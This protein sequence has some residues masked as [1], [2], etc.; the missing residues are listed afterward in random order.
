VATLAESLTTLEQ[1]KATLEKTVKG[2]QGDLKSQ[3]ERI[4][5]LKDSLDKAEKTANA[6]TSELSKVNGELE[7]AKKRFFSSQRPIQKW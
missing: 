1:E 6:K 5:E 7:D 2:L 4:F 3:Q